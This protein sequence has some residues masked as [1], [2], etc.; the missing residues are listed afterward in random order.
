MDLKT[1][2][3]R[4]NFS[5]FLNLISYTWVKNGQKNVKKKLGNSYK[6]TTWLFWLISSTKYVSRKNCRTKAFSWEAP[7]SIVMK[8]CRRRCNIWNSLQGCQQHLVTILN[9]CSCVGIFY[10]RLF[11]SSDAKYCI[12]QFPFPSALGGLTKLV[13]ILKFNNIHRNLFKIR[14]DR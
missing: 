2:P 11:F 4:Y 5:K 12:P 6:L 1:K 9:W 3:P 14:W 7:E 8:V 10:T 13:L